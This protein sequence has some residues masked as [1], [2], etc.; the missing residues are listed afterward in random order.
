MESRK[1]VKKKQTGKGN[2]ENVKLEGEVSLTYTLAV[3]KYIIKVINILP[4]L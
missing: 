3:L 1:N 2:I 4:I